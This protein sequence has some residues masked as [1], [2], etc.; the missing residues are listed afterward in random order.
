MSDEPKKPDEK[1]PEPCKCSLCGKSAV[2]H[3]TEV[4]L[5]TGEVRELH[6]CEEHGREHYERAIRNSP[7][8]TP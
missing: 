8:P 1:L 6:L 5:D 2:A 3:A 4:Y 7:G